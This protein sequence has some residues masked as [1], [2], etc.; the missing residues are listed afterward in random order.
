M[1][2]EEAS[3]W[4]FSVISVSDTNSFTLIPN[5]KKDKVWNAI[6]FLGGIDVIGHPDG[7]LFNEQDIIIAMTELSI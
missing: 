1:T 2:R 6:V 4:A 7:Y 3:G 5:E